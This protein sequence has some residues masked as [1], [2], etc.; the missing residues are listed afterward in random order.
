VFNFNHV[1]STNTPVKATANAVFLRTGVSSGGG[2][3]N[4]SAD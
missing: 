1:P 3:V 2:K 4:E